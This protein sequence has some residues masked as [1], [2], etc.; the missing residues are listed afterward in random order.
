MRIVRLKYVTFGIEVK[1]LSEAKPKLNHIEN[2]IEKINRIRVI[3]EH[4]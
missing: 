2:S 1:N 4:K 3:M